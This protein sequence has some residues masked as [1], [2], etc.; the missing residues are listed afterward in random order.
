MQVCLLRCT[1]KS[2]ILPLF[3]GT[4]MEFRVQNRLNIEGGYL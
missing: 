4:I 3:I 2:V 1:Y